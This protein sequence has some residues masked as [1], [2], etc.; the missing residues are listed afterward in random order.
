MGLRELTLGRASMERVRKGRWTRQRCHITL[1]LPIWTVNAG[2][3]A[4]Y[5]V[6]LGSSWGT[7]FMGK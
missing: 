5:D 3:S 4:L 6:V 1:E 7:E 2:S